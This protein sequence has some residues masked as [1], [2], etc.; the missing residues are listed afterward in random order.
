MNLIILGA[1]ALVL[2]V[3]EQVPRLRFR[4][5]RLFRRFFVTDLIYLLTGYLAP[6]SLSLAYII[7]GSGFVG[8][9]IGLPRFGDLGL[10]MWITLPLA[11]VA[12]DLGQYTAHYLMHRYDFLW[13]FHKIHHSS[14]T[15]DWLA[16]FR[17]H[18]V[19]QL[20]RRIAGP[21]LLILSGF[22]VSASLIASGVF[23]VWAEFNHSNL[24]LNLRFLE[25]I[26][27]S[28]RLHKIHHVHRTSEQNLGTLFTFWDRI[29]GTFISEGPS[30][31]AVF[32][33]G[34]P[35]YPQAWTTQLVEPILRIVRIRRAS[36]K[37]STTI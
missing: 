5:S 34:E 35:N 33:N 3:L 32:G 24:K 30:E 11:L 17:S 16:T 14:P 13:E 28:P 23:I 2:A 12:L 1:A 29:R 31:G 10:S 25:P 26:V 20:L 19:E 9:T 4:K 15:I 6:A 18:F 22:P 36:Y 37:V 7:V 8:K 27:I 21:L